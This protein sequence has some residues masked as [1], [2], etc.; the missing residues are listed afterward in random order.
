MTLKFV[1]NN[2]HEVHQQQF[3]SDL[4]E[5]MMEVLKEHKIYKL[6]VQIIDDDLQEVPLE[7]LIEDTDST[8]QALFDK[9]EAKKELQ[10]KPMKALAL[11][12]FSFLC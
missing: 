5:K 9:K 3:L 4:Q 1:N 6:K 12:N 11:F 8:K 7:T 2:D 10:H